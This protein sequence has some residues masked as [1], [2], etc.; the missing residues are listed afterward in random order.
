MLPRT[1]APISE[2]IPDRNTN[3]ACHSLCPQDLPLPSEATQDKF[4]LLPCDRCHIFEDTFCNFSRPTIIFYAV[5]FLEPYSS[6]Y[7]SL[8]QLQ[9]CTLYLEYSDQVEV[10]HLSCNLI[11]CFWHTLNRFRALLRFTAGGRKSPKR[12]ISPTFLPNC[13][14]GPLHLCSVIG[15]TIFSFR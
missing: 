4:V 9:I 7:P 8:D 1:G 11:I 15:N 6:G 10:Q 3:L 14:V 12:E 13:F 5:G 2:R